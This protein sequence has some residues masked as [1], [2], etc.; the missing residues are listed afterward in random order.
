MHKVTPLPDIMI[1]PNGA[2]RRKQD[3]AA[4][5]IAITETI[6]TTR[7][8]IKQGATG[9]HL[10][11][12]DNDGKHMLDSGIYLEALS[13]FKLA[14]PDFPV[15]I[16]TEAVGQYSSAE[17]RKIVRDIAPKSVSISIAEMLAYG[18]I[19]EAHKLYDWCRETQISVQHI[20]YD[21]QDLKRI[22]MMFP[23]TNDDQLQLLFVLGRYTKNQ[24][25]APDDLN[26]FYD[27]L[28]NTKPNAD[29]AI[30]A[31]G[32]GETDCLAE[33]NKRGG[34]VRVGFENSIWNKDG[35]LAKNNAERVAEVVRAISKNS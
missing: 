7:A 12:R 25:S 28:M 29:W 6:D 9:L 13:E 10:H 2:R 33:A 21:V 18:E 22:E 16:T 35:S 8:C 17:Q 34:K 31:F 26:P 30:C 11:I 3:H 5:P 19:K 32:R 20:I 27:W 24:Q 4:L 1:A 15:Q 14:L 23:D